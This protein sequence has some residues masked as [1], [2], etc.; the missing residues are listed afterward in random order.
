MMDTLRIIGTR[1]MATLGILVAFNLVLFAAWF[2]WATPLKTD[3]EKNLRK[4]DGEINKLRLSIV[5]IKDEMVYYNEH[6]N[7]FNALKESGFI[8]SGEED[9]TQAQVLEFIAAQRTTNRIINMQY[10][11]AEPSVIK[12]RN[13]EAT[14]QMLEKRQITLSNIAAFFDTDIFRLLHQLNTQASGHTRITSVSFVRPEPSGFEKSLERIALGTQES[15]INA[16]VMLDWYNMVPLPEE[17]LPTTP[18]R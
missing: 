9:S 16:T 10:E 8:L 6:I 11:I 14:K 4:L 7:D 1:L 12:S 17:N 18:R 2:L 3:A 5:N 15:L 13:I